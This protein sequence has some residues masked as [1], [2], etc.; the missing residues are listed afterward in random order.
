MGESLNFIEV[1]LAIPFI[2]LS[3]KKFDFKVKE[4]SLN[5]HWIATAHFGEDWMSWSLDSSLNRLWTGY[6]AK[7]GLSHDKRI[8]NSNIKI[9]THAIKIFPIIGAWFFFHIFFLLISPI[10]RL[11]SCLLCYNSFSF[12]LFFGYTRAWGICLVYV[13]I[14][15]PIKWHSPPSRASAEI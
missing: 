11:L 12:I 3:A 2:H 6:G 4:I 8:S 5:I 13:R 15:A 1:R 7:T 10:A 9:M 14:Q